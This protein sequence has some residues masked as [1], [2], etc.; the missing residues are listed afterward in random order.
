MHAPPIEGLRDNQYQEAK[1]KD[2][3]AGTQHLRYSQEHFY[4]ILS[5]DAA[6]CANIAP[7]S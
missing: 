4:A 5:N 6:R 3:A 2:A 1:L 7:A